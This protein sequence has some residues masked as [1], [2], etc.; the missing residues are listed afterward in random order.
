MISLNVFMIITQSVYSQNKPEPNKADSII[1]ILDKVVTD[2]KAPGIIAAIISG[3]G[4]IAIGS[5]GVRKFG[6]NVPFS[7]N[8]AVHLGSCSKAMTATMLATLVA[9]GKL[10]WETKLIE[11]IPEIKDKIHPTYHS[12]TLW[13]LLTHRADVPDLWT[14]DQS[15]SKERRLAV[16]VEMLK[17]EGNH[18]SG[19]FN[20]SNLGYIAAAAMAEKITGLS[21]EVLM[22]QRLFDPLGMRS[23]GFGA[24]GVPNKTDQPWGHQKSGDSWQPTQSDCSE[25]LGP[26]GRIHCTIEDWAKFLSLQLTNKNQILDQVFLNKLIEPVGFYAGGWGVSKQDWAKGSLI[27]HNGS[28]GRWF[29]TVLVAPELNRAFVVSTNSR[30]FSVTED[31]CNEIITKLIR[32]E[33]KA[34]NN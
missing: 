13:Q 14:F 15:K 31:M 29:T 21:W 32:M 22:K 8:D 23:A 19:E 9:E 16:L 33:L 11:A 3:D 2:E 24:P 7:I 17:T 25:A 10:S 26:A 5:A 6:T 4:I 34:K 30:D 1:Q 28:N 18:K 12:I 27:T 20:Y